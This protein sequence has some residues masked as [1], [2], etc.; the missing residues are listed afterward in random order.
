LTLPLYCPYF[1]DI[2][3]V[4]LFCDT[5]VYGLIDHEWKRICRFFC[6]LIMYVFPWEIQ[7]V[8]WDSLNWFN[9]ATIL[10]L[11]PARMWISQSHMLWSLFYIQR[12]DCLL[13]WYWLNCWQSL[14]KLSFH[15]HDNVLRTKIRG[16][17]L[18]SIQG[19]KSQEDDSSWTSICV[20]IMISSS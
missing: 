11:S 10:W 4:I 2:Y 16:I 8:V 20:I 19:I 1:P 15:N 14:F 6:R 18:L 13:C 5:E 9:P 12:V 7:I 17:F 3:V